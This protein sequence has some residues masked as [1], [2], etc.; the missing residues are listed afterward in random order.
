MASDDRRRDDRPIILAV[1]FIWPVSMSN[2]ANGRLLYGIRDRIWR[3]SIISNNLDFKYH[4]V[5]SIYLIHFKITY[6]IQIISRHCII[7]IIEYLDRVKEHRI[8]YFAASKGQ[9]E[10]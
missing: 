2:K 1:C 4:I 5:Q 3:S 6:L 7:K 10:I 9:S 8:I